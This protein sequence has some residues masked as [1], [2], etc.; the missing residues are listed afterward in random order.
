MQKEQTQAYPEIQSE[1]Q[2]Q[3]PTQSQ[4]S[5]QAP[6]EKQKQP[7]TRRRKP[8]QR[9]LPAQ[10]QKQQQPQKQ[11]P[12]KQQP[13]KQ[14]EK[15]TEEQDTSASTVDMTASGSRVLKITHPPSQHDNRQRSIKE[16]PFGVQKAINHALHQD[17][18]IPYLDTIKYYIKD[19]VGKSS[20]YTY[21]VNTNGKNPTLSNSNKEW[22]QLAPLV[23]TTP[24]TLYG[25]PSK[26]TLKVSPTL[27]TT[28]KSQSTPTSSSLLQMGDYLAYPAFNSYPVQYSLNVAS[29]V[30]NRLPSYY[31]NRLYPKVPYLYDKNINFAVSDELQ[32]TPLPPSQDQDIL[33]DI[34]RQQNGV[35]STSPVLFPVTQPPNIPNPIVKFYAAIPK[36]LKELKDLNVDVNDKETLALVRT[37]VE[38]L[39]KHNPHL[40]VVPKKVEN[41]E[42][43]VHVTPKPGY[44]QPADPTVQS[45]TDKN[46]LY[47]NK[48][49]TENDVDVIKVTA[50]PTIKQLNEIEHS[51]AFVKQ[52][53][54]PIENNEVK[55]I[56]LKMSR[57]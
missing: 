17:F 28:I 7:Q 39:K 12:Q 43:I 50:R 29:N 22:W 45:V 48:F 35:S 10:N 49:V 8:Q 47:L 41:N 19:P 6:E 52:L 40:D 51:H 32:S 26:S 11:L 23:R 18:N 37:A 14:K 38:S 2:P 55:L 15:S 1:A 36:E 3:E 34:V 56:L 4:E 9:R 42:L 44:S 24:Q 30:P 5:S 21:T 16:L 33:N 57:F 20:Q 31:T 25:V 46:L 54:D 53:H 27:S 13:Q